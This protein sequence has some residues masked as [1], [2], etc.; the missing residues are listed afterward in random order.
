MPPS[1]A[2]TI[3]AN[4]WEHFPLFRDQPP[5]AALP[6]H[7]ADFRPETENRKNTSRELPS[8]PWVELS[9]STKLATSDFSTSTKLATSE[10]QHKC[11]RTLQGGSRKATATAQRVLP[12]ATGFLP[13]PQHYLGLYRILSYLSISN[14]VY[15]LFFY[16]FYLIGTAYGYTPQR[17]IYRAA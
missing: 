7:S 15:N 8:L 13:P 16:F 6:H 12:L 10:T 1:Q 3:G 11:K 17:T 9:T 4:A 14:V 5:C 2:P